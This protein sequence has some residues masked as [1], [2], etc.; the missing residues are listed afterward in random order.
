MYELQEIKTHLK[1]YRILLRE[2][3]RQEIRLA[4]LER[5][6]RHPALFAAGKDLTLLEKMLI[7]RRS[8]VQTQMTAA[9]HQC[10]GIEDLIGRVEG[11]TESKTLLYRQILS[12]H[13]LDGLPFRTITDSMCYHER[14]IRRLHREGLEAANML[15][16]GERSDGNDL[17]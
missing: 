1:S 9:M 6:A 12:S 7:R 11:D 3:R 15:W 2:V 16:K 13:Y 5:M 17:E 4:E 8:A 10:R 14:H